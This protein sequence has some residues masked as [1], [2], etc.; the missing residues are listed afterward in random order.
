MTDADR[1]GLFPRPIG[2]RLMIAREAKKMSLD[3]VARV[4]RVPTRHLQ[5]IDNGEWDAL[6][7]VT[8]SVG[9]ARAYA[10]AVGLDGQKIAAELREQLGTGPNYSSASMPYEPADPARV[11]PRS[12]ALIAG[13]LAIALAIGY[14]VWRSGA[15]DD[16]A[17]DEAEVAAV[18][19]P[20]V[21]APAPTPTVVP[22]QPLAG[23]A[24]G[25]PVVLTATEAVWLR[26]YEPG[27][28]RLFENTLQAG[29][30]FTV[31]SNTQ[32]PLLL[33]GRPNALRVTV[34][35]NVIPPLGPPERTVADLSLAANDLL[36]RLQPQGGASAP[37]ATAPTPAAT[38]GGAATPPAR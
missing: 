17:I 7:A 8:Y 28:G 16:S 1:D 18:D 34:G 3:D 9:F 36:A 11:P 4:T 27:G 13:L 24:A 22:N 5:H 21:P 32:R 31:P 6:P 25:G 37:G 33:T 30:S 29:Q 20:I 26:V 2:E 10:N 35:T 38:P 15:V 23:P 12:L 19:T 14:L